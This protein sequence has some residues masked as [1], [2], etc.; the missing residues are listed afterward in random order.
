MTEI[1]VYAEETLNKA[2]N[3]IEIDQCRLHTDNPGSNNAHEIS[4]NLYARQACNFRQAIPGDQGRRYLSSAVQFDLAAD[5]TV[6]WV[7]FWHQN[8]FVEAHK[9]PIGRTFVVGGKGTLTTSTY[10]NLRGVTLA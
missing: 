8:T 2:I 1:A 5:D 9:L 6:A 3:A 10:L 7:S 4:S